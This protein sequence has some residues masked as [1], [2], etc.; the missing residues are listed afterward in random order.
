M[1]TDTAEQRFWAKVDKAGPPHPYDP[2]LGQCWRWT[3]A[4]S[5]KGYG[6][7]AY[8]WGTLA[9]RFSYALEHGPIPDGLNILHSCDNPPCANPEHLYAG[10][11]AD[12]AVDRETRGRGRQGD[13]LKNRTHCP[14]G[15]PYDEVNTHRK[16][17]GSRVCRAC[18]RQR[19]TSRRCAACNRENSA[20][21]SRSL[22]KPVRNHYKP[23][24]TH[25]CKR[26]TGQV[27]ARHG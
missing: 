13:H 3:A 9:P 22:G 23:P 18:W 1:N 4:T 20:A 11:H 7:F 27:E 12:N 8:G 15:H 16:A 5:A 2:A 14:Q 26:L 6:L 19:A 21:R 24:S 10:T 25:T 17:D